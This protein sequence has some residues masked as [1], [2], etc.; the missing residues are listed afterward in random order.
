MP[1]KRP[2]TD[3]DRQAD[4]RRQADS[5]A[6]NADAAALEAFH[7]SQVRDRNRESHSASR[8]A[9]SPDPSAAAA[10]LDAFHGSQ[11]RDRNRESHS[12]SRAAARAADENADAAALEAFN[13]SQARDANRISQAESRAAARAADENADAAA[14]EAFHASQ[15]RDAHRN[16]QS[17]SRVRNAP[18]VDPIATGAQLD[19]LLGMTAFTDQDLDRIV[20]MYERNVSA[21]LAFF[22]VNTQVAFGMRRDID[23]DAQLWNL[24]GDPTDPNSAANG[25]PG[26]VKS[27]CINKYMTTM[28]QRELRSCV[29]CGVWHPKP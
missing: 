20:S 25:V 23:M 1:P 9:A 29:A 12:A 2:R 3:A 28:G 18:P 27:D 7:A 8:A 26:S 13:V 4:Q 11:V 14:L 22:S 5:R 10:A 6:E 16:S 19:A 24:L 21:A 15:V 17:A